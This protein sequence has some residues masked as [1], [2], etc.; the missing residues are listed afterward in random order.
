MTG[1]QAA[2]YEQMSLWPGNAYFGYRYDYAQEY[3]EVMKELWT[4]GVSNFKGKHFTMNDCKLLPK[5][6]QPIKIVAAG[7]SERGT[8]FAA[9]YADYNFCGASGHNT[10]TTFRPGNEAL[11]KAAQEAGRDVGA[12]VLFMVVADETDE[13]AQAKWDWY[14]EGV[15]LDATSW[16]ASQANKDTRADAKATASR[17]SKSDNP[18][19]LNG[20]ALIGS[21]EKVAALLDEASE[22]PGTKGIMLIFDDFLVGLD[23]FGKKI[24][25][26]MKCRSHIKLGTAA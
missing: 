9:Q 17:I 7:Q 4:D 25:P 10:P 5:P 24:Q 3:V 19:N 1:W 26:L 16:V 14:A 8:K 18:V 13:K 15:D 6:S 20:G 21:F 23:N 2:E 12:M 11:V 22:I